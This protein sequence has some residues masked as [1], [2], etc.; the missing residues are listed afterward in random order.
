MTGE[1]G[2]GRE[3]RGDREGRDRRANGVYTPNHHRQVTRYTF[4]PVKGW[5]YARDITSDVC[6]RACVREG[7]PELISLK[8]RP[9]ER[10]SIRALSA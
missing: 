9:F 5:F 8:E 3:R 7:G 6:V 1:W 2:E 4:S 10:A